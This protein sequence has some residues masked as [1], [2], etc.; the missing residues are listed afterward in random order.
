MFGL[1]NVQS[2]GMSIAS[3]QGCTPPLS[4]IPVFLHLWHLFTIFS[5][6]CKFFD[7]QERPRVNLFT[8]IT[9]DEYVATGVGFPGSEPSELLEVPNRCHCDVSFGYHR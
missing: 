1:A 9:P 5:P 7:I 8:L 4:A 3:P 6:P 2:Q